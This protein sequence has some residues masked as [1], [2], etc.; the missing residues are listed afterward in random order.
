[1]IQLNAF[2][3][4]GFGKACAGIGRGKK[5]KMFATLPGATL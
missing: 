4:N 2:L 5:Q 1:M 3:E